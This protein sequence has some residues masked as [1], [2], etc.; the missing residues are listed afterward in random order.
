MSGGPLSQK[1][2]ELLLIVPGAARFEGGSHRPAESPPIEEI[3]HS[4]AAL[5]ECGN[6][7]S[8]LIM[9]ARY[10]APKPLSIFTTAVPQ[11]QLLS[12]ASKADSPPKLAP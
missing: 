4:P 9:P 1:L 2:R 6:Y 8:L 5:C 11:A 7:S 3:M 10:P 12:M